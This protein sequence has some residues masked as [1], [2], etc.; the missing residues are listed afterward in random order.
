MVRSWPFYFWEVGSHGRFQARE[1]QR[2]GPEAGWEDERGWREMWDLVPRIGGAGR[3][4][5]EGTR[6]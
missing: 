1:E 5:R 3:H 2:Q 6:S 4:G